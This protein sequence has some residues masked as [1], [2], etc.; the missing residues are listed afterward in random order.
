VSAQEILKMIETV[1]H[2]HESKLDEID[3]RV[4][5][6]LKRFPVEA[7]EFIEAVEKEF[8]HWQIIYRGSQGQLC[9]RTVNDI[10][11]YTRSRDELKKLRMAGAGFSISGCYNFIAEVEKQ[12]EENGMVYVGKWDWHFK[13]P[14]LPTEELS[15]LHAIIQAIEFER[16]K[17][18]ELSKNPSGWGQE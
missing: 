14:M 13:S 3:A 7:Y 16:T 17:E 1:N 4:W 10:P 9:W 6:Y 18:P 15:E 11:D 5:C 8:S 2:H 12:K